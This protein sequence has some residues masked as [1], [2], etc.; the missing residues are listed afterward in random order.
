M[1]VNLNF[2]YFK[3]LGFPYKLWRVWGIE[4]KVC[5]GL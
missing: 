4:I 3:V 2:D 1:I 5:G